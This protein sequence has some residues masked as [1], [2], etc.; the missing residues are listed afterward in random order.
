MGKVFAILIKDHPKLGPWFH[1]FFIEEEGREHYVVQERLTLESIKDCAAD[2][3]DTQKEVIKIVEDYSPGN[4]KK[5]FSKVKE[6]DHAFIQSLE[7]SK[8][9]SLV[10]PYI[11]Y[12]MRKCLDLIRREGAEFY[13]RSSPAVIYKQDKVKMLSQPAE[14]VFNFLKNENGT[15][16]FQTIRQGEQEIKLKSK[17][18]YILVNQPCY[19]LLGNQI[20]HFKN[21]V[22]G[23]KLKAFFDKD[24]VIVPLSLEN[25]FYGGFVKKCVRDFSEN[26]KGLTIH[27]NVPEKH[28]VLSLEPDM[29]GQFCIF[30]RYIYGEECVDPIKKQK[31]FVHFNKDKVFELYKRNLEWESEIISFLETNGL[32]RLRENNFICKQEIDPE[33][34]KQGFQLVNWLNE[35]YQKLKDAG[36]EIAQDRNNIQYF[37]GNISLDISFAEKNDWFDVYAMAHFGDKFSIPLFK[38]GKYLLNGIRE[39]PL[40]DGTIAILPE[41]WFDKYG[42][43]ITFGEEFKDRIKVRKVHGPMLG[44]AFNYR[45]ELI[46]KT[47]AALLQE[48]DVQLEQPKG[49]QAKLRSYQLEGF[50][51]LLFLRKHNLGGCLADD[52]GLGKTLQTI[53]LLIQH[54]SENNLPTIL[55]SWSDKKNPQIDLFEQGEKRI[56]KPSLIIMPASLIHNWENE[57][58]RFAKGIKL[59]KYT[60]IIRQSLQ[61]DIERAQVVI[62]TYGTVR[63]DIDILKKVKFDYIIL[64]ESQTI[65]NPETGAAKNIFK[66][67]S[68]HRLALSGTPIENS[69]VDIWS[70]MNFLNP[71]LLGD[72]GFFKKHFV[73][74]IEKGKDQKKQKKLQLLTAPFILRRTKAQVAKELPD[75]NEEYIFCQMTDGQKNLSETE[76]LKVRDHLLRTKAKGEKLGKSSIIILQAL[77]KMR[78]IAGHPRMLDSESKIESGKF[79]EVISNLEDRIMGGHKILLFSSF[80]KHL[81]IYKEYLDKKNIPYSYMTGKTVNREAVITEFQQ[82]KNRQVFL[83]SI[84]TG[85]V[86]LNLTQAD[87]V[88]ILDPWW[89][90]SVEMQAIN[91]AHRIGQDK[92][93]FAY[94][95]ISEN[96][97]EEKIMG[98]QKRKQKLADDL[99]YNPK[100]I[101]NLSLEEIQSFF[102]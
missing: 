15:L 47:Y 65:K 5:R 94:R 33:N 92:H 98:L 64:D 1:P 26:V 14:V 85:G 87:Y 11:E 81:D 4:L 10:R 34:I 22:D 79:N 29:F 2:L 3:S 102:N 66:L 13:F 70:Q 52:M 38:L 69:L 25:K 43:I 89:N 86:G 67:T 96:S 97:I 40:P 12:Q 39:Y 77:S 72:L 68:D 31:V 24:H 37:T 8:V 48:N 56:H 44:R 53:A 91:R 17:K 54:L 36:F 60:G 93:V 32:E 27:E 90:S 50:N 76:K 46:N 88:F 9:E 55:E 71:G 73:I 28:P 80:V 84:K 7:Q 41:D 100:L 6:S 95:F 99:I 51:W 21:N 59:L 62:S 19:L 42:D 20:F 78:Q 23:K 30:L 63:Q 49:L 58:R 83:V 16:Y 61:S 74:P 18:A 82:D 45:N 35:N 75:L 101:E 57:I